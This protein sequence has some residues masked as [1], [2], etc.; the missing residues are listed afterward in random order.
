MEI[1]PGTAADVDAVRDIVQRAYDVYVAR[2]GRRPGPMDADYAAIVRAGDL[3]VADDGGIAVGLLVLVAAPDHL[4]IENVAVDPERQGT[5]VGRA[6]LDFA[7]A[8]ARDQ[9]LSMVRL[10]T[11]ALMSENQALYRRRGFREDE[12]RAEAGFERVFM[13]KRV[14]A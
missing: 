1:R 9:R 13:S 14:G 10:Y 2:I 11:H 3:W 12:R 7:E 8:I 4:L 5:G 6:L